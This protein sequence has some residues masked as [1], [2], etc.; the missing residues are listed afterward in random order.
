MNYF[1]VKQRALTLLGGAMGVFALSAAPTAWRS[2]HFIPAGEV[3]Y[4]AGYRE[5]THVKSAFVG[6]A[7]ASFKTVGGFHHIYANGKAM[8]GYRTRVFPEGS[9]VVFDRLESNESAG[10]FDEA[11]RRQ[12]DVMV[13]DSVQFAATG[14]WGFQTFARN[15]TERVAPSPQQCFSCHDR[16]QKD[17]LVLSRYRK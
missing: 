3:A 6:P 4:P 10:R 11:G 13:R 9:V 15:T 8:A 2:S 16:L 14:G 17:G 12:I 7:H 5:W 1:R